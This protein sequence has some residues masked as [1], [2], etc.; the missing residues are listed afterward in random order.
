MKSCETYHFFLAAI[1]FCIYSSLDPFTHLSHFSTINPYTVHTSLTYLV[2]WQAAPIWAVQE[3]ALHQAPHLVAPEQTVF[4]KIN[5]QA[6]RGH[7]VGAGDDQ[8]VFSF[9]RGA[10]HHRFGSYVCPEQLP[11]K[12]K[13]SRYKSKN[14]KISVLSHSTY[15]TKGWTTIAFGICKP[16]LMRVSLFCSVSEL[17]LIVDWLKY[18][19]Q[20]HW[21]NI[22]HTQKIK[23]MLTLTFTFGRSSTF[24]GAPSR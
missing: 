14:S 1:H 19:K 11:L 9:Q 17:R 21:R 3:R 8:T 24:C 5:G 20:I 10:L 16:S 23:C 12:V 15:F 18:K 7:K 13:K 4:C 6:A 22:L 2:L